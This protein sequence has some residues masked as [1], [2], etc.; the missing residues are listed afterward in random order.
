MIGIPGTSGPPSLAIQSS[1]EEWEKTARSL[2]KKKRYAH[3]MQ[4]FERA[5]LQNE[6]AVSNAYLLREEARALPSGE[7]HDDLRTQAFTRAA[8]AFIKSAP[9]ASVERS[10][11][12]R[13]AAECFRECV[14]L[15]DAARSYV[16][17]GEFDIG[18]QLYLDSEMHSHAIRIIHRHEREMRHSIVDQILFRCR[19]YYF[20]KS[21]LEYV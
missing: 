1:Q 18:A 4:C 21:E 17:A 3:A 20:Q 10:T 9:S 6:A 12:Y 7:H 14:R 8:E 15:P 16:D 13:I 5:S 2:F 11:Y 19:L